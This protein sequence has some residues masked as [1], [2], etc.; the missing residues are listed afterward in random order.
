MLK[1]KKLLLLV[2]MVVLM[3]LI[4]NIVKADD[5]DGK[6]TTINISAPKPISGDNL[7]TVSDVHA[8]T[9]LSP[10]PTITVNEIN[11]KKFNA[12]TNAYENTTDTKFEM[13]SKYRL[14]IELEFDEIYYDADPRAIM[15]DMD[16]NL[17]GKGGTDGI[18]G[19]QYY[20]DFV[21]FEEIKTL[22]FTMPTPIVGKTQYGIEDAVVKINGSEKL[23]VI[24]VGWDK[25][26][27][28]KNQYDEDTYI[29]SEQLA[30]V[31]NGNYEEDNPD[32]YKLKQFEANKK[33]AV[34]IVFVCPNNYVYADDMVVKFNGEVIP[35]EMAMTDETK[36]MFMTTGSGDTEGSFDGAIYIMGEPK[37]EEKEK[38]AEEPAAT[39]PAKTKD[40]SK[41]QG[42]IPYAGGTFIIIASALLLI[43]G[44]IYAYRKNNDLKG[45]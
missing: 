2:L 40:A 28:E 19:F 3:L 38:E 37:V 29:V 8:T 27:E 30:G 23:K 13:G 10:S 1:N 18:A 35:V 42:T 14:Y 39:E 44:G 31:M 7:Y 12:E 15:Y 21:A 4:P 26:N 11:W 33:Y 5:S 41:A 36:N 22:D 32:L 9:T 16:G 43:A 20:F 17:S 6:I 34:E 24:G 45:I 25:Y